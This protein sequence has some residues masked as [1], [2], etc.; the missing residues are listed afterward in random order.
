MLVS[1]L[2]KV[3]VECPIETLGKEPFVGTVDAVCC[4]SSVTLDKSFTECF[5]V[6]VEC[7]WHTAESLFPVAKAEEPQPAKESTCNG[8][9]WSGAPGPGPTN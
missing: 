8:L 6:F 9:V 3:F 7:L 4:L 2:G 1:A 5:L